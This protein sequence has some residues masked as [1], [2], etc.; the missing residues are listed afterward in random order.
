M[1]FLWATWMGKQQEYV[2]VHKQRMYGQSYRT[3]KEAGL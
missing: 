1:Y 2:V 3:R